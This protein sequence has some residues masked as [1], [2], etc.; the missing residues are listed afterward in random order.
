MTAARIDRGTLFTIWGA[1]GSAPTGDP[2]RSRFGGDTICFEVRR[3]DEAAP[4]LVIDLGSASLNLGA[5]LARRAA[6][7][8][9]P[10]AAEILLS[11]LHLD[12]VIGLPFFGP[13][14]TPGAQLRLHCGVVDSAWDLQDKLSRFAAPPFFPVHPLQMETVRYARFDPTRPFELCGMRITPGLSHHPGGCC[15]FR[16][17]G[18]DGA[19]AIIGDHEHGDPEADARMAELAR[20]ADLLLYDGAYDDDDFARRRGWGHSTWQHGADFAR[21]AGAG[22]ALIYHHQ[23]EHSDDELDAIEARLRRRLPV[24]AMARQNMRILI[25]PE[26]ARVLDPAETVRE[27]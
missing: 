24:A 4:P 3:L 16:I 21:E 25:G 18:P 2:R 8:G 27:D 22:R 12:H 10:I 9:R 11:H 7:A 1:G 6:A 5:D 19:I 20:G 23:P 17:E 26:G 15:A 13:F 14:Y